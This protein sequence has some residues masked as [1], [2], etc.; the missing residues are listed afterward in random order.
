MASGDLLAAGAGR[1]SPVRGCLRADQRERDPVRVADDSS[2]AGP[3][4]QHNGVYR[5]LLRLWWR[6]AGGG[7]PRH[8]HL[9]V[10]GILCLRSGVEREELAM[11]YGT[12]A[13]IG[14]F[15]HAVERAGRIPGG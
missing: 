15:D 8:L 11:P 1:E 12:T 9:R 2:R 4:D 14:D 10:R 3:T 13:A 7:Y 5:V 6:T